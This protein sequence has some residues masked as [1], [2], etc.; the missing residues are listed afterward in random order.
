MKIEL[1]TKDSLIVITIK[2]QHLLQGLNIQLGELLSYK[3]LR[4]FSE[5]TD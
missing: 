4:T 3:H 5:I 2:L 1:S